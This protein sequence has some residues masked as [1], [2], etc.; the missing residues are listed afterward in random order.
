MIVAAR[1]PSSRL[2]ARSRR[3]VFRVLFADYLYGLLLRRLAAA[4]GSLQGSGEGPAIHARY[5]AEV[6][7]VMA[8]GMR[9]E[10]EGGAEA[11]DP[12]GSMVARRSDNR[13][14]GFSWRLA[15]F[16]AAF[17]GFS[18]IIMPFF[19]AWLQAKGLD[20]RA[21]GIVLAVP[22]FIRLISVPSLA[23]LADRRNAFRGALIS[24]AFGSA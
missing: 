4:L 2:V 19:P 14:D 12:A 7:Y 21:T 20:S 9:R 23:R 18:G 5:P 17:F 15:A 10:F 16:Y 1:P 22:M 8:S 3:L 11:A 13:S 24:T 6:D